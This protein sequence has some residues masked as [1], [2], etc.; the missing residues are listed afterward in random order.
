MIAVICSCGSSVRSSFSCADRTPAAAV[1]TTAKT[2]LF[3][4]P[5][6]LGPRALALGLLATRH[7]IPFRHVRVDGRRGDDVDARV[8]DLRRRLLPVDDGVVWELHGL[9]AP[10]EILLPEEHLHLPHR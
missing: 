7:A 3:M 8:D 2:I 9:A 6:R 10:A 5:P 4:G 1:R